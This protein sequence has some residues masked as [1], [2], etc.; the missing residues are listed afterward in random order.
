MPYSRKISFIPWLDCKLNFLVTRSFRVK[1]VIVVKHSIIKSEL[2]PNIF[3]RDIP[4]CFQK[5]ACLLTATTARLWRVF[6]SSKFWRV[7]PSSSMRNS[8]LP[9]VRIPDNI[10]NME[11][12]SL[13]VKLSKPIALITS[14]S[15]FT[16]GLWGASDEEFVK[17]YLEKRGRGRK[18]RGYEGI[19]PVLVIVFCT[20]T[21]RLFHS[22]GEIIE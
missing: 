8:K 12:C 9:M 1:V 21:E 10:R 14:S 5:L 6:S 20:K 19:L 16:A 7:K 22:H 15:E 17:R 4:I 3:Y 2:T 18:F 11:C 13:S